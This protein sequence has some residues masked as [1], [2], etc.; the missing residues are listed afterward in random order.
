[1]ILIQFVFKAKLCILINKEM[2]AAG[3]EKFIFIASLDFNFLFTLNLHAVPLI[4]QVD[5]YLYMPLIFY[6][7]LGKRKIVIMHTETY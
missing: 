6:L 4:K 1:M 2:T 5:V 7:I 3:L